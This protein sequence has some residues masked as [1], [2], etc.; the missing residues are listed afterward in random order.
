MLT[1]NHVD[2][3]SVTFDLEMMNFDLEI[4][5]FDLGNNRIVRS[6]EYK[7]KYGVLP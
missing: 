1:R 4:L 2:L 7:F 5:N 6:R 3:E